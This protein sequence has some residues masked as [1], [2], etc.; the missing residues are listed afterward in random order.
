MYEIIIKRITAKSRSAVIYS[1][2]PYK[3][4]YRKHYSA[5]LLSLLF[6]SF[7][8]SSAHAYL[9]WDRGESNLGNC[10]ECHGAFMFSPYTSLSDSDGVAWNADL[11]SGHMDTIGATCTDC[12]ELTVE[13]A[14]EFITEATVMT[15]HSA[16]LAV[17]AG[18]ECT[19]CHET[20]NNPTL[21]TEPT[22]MTPHSVHLAVNAGAE[23][24]DCH[25]PATTGTPNLN[26]EPSLMTPPSIHLAVNAGAECIDCHELS[27][28]STPEL[29]TEP[30]GMTPDTA[31]LAVNAGAECTNCHETTPTPALNTNPTLITPDSAHL[32][33]DAGAECTDCHEL[34]PNLNT[35]PTLMTPHSVHL[36]INAGAECTDCHDLAIEDYFALN[37]DVSIT[38][39]NK[40]HGRSADALAGG[41][42]GALDTAGPGL[43]DGLRARHLLMG[44]SECLTCHHNDQD[45]VGEDIPPSRMTTLGISPCSDAFFGRFGLD[46]DGNGLYDLDEVN[47]YGHTIAD[48]DADSVADYRDQCSGTALGD[49]VDSKGCSL[50]DRP[51]NCDIDTTAADCS[52]SSPLG[53]DANNEIGE[54]NTPTASAGNGGGGSVSLLSVLF[55]LLYRLKSRLIC[56]QRH[57]TRQGFFSLHE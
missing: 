40:C 33:V 56:G 17:N 26:T 47:C 16:H 22:L 36:A 13:N 53:N 18:A 57:I 42:D 44:I 34:T 51:D 27:A 32:A 7:W 2:S 5:C 25:E 28:G 11:K 23:C 4:A 20:S 41:G 21:N 24:A 1:Q 50:I 52:D 43:G 31:H 55:F 48:E 38:A 15:T 30:T 9:T 46:N 49:P 8:V 39:C 19:D 54:T 3:A 12:H 45:P 14:P 29:N 6:A 37:S 10:A 35:E